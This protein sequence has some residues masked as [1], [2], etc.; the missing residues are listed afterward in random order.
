MRITIALPFLNRTGGIRALLH[1]AN[2]LQ[3]RGHAVT[4]VVPMWPYRF[5]HSRGDVLRDRV[6]RW[7][8]RQWPWFPLRCR[9]RHVPWLTSAFLPEADIVVGTSWP[10]IE[11]LATLDRSRGRKVHVVFHHEGDT[12]DERRVAATYRV[13]CFRITAA[14][15]VQDE[16][17][18]RYGCTVDAVV[19]L[20]VDS[21]TFYPSDSPVGKNVLMLYHDAPRKGGGDGL[22]ALAALMHSDPG[23]R[24]RICGTVPP[25]SLPP[26][27]D[28]ELEPDD[29][30]LRARYSA[31]TVLLYPSLYEGFGL[32]PLEAMACGTPVVTTAVGA[33][34]EYA[35]S[36][37]NAIVVALGDVAAMVA[38]LGAVLNDSALRSRLSIQGLAIARQ[39]TWAAAASAFDAALQA[40]R[41]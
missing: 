34:P 8:A 14:R 24:V 12:G 18:S 6:Q 25:A 11:D 33:V 20:G 28:F 41:R 21:A 3:D 17:E 4:V 31:A 23:V 38:G 39:R 16:I 9:L 15:A 1:L 22:R 2:A 5:H 35:V 27:A 32:P 37:H 10:V 30:A 19:P 36:G 29:Q 7:R 13:P 26:G 40:A